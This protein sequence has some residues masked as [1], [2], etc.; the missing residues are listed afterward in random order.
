MRLAAWAAIGHVS[1]ELLVLVL[2]VGQSAPGRS[3]VVAMA[4]EMSAVVGLGVLMFRGAGIGYVVMGAYGVVRLLLGALAVDA[5][6]TGEIERVDPLFIWGVLIAMPF[7]L[8]WIIGLIAGWR[9]G[10][11][12]AGT[13]EPGVRAA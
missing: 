1:C 2:M 3:F 10:R 6:I 8:A 11:R 9:A 4:V 7:A 5:V 13:A 12:G